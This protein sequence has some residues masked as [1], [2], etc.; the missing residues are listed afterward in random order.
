M[1]SLQTSHD[2]AAAAV[3]VT[4]GA[5]VEV[6]S[7]PASANSAVDA[8]EDFCTWANDAARAW[9]PAALFG[10]SWERQSST[11]GALLKVRNTGGVWS[12]APNGAALA[13]LGIPAQGPGIVASGSTAGV[14]T[15]APGPGGLLPLRLGQ[16]WWDKSPG[17]ASGVGT[18]RPVVPAFSP[19][20]GVCA[21]IVGPVETMR[22]P[23]IVK[24]CSHP[25]RAWLRLSSVQASEW[26]VPPAGY[27][28]LRLGLGA[29]QRS[30]AGVRLW[31]FELQLVGEAA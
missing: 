1:L 20:A 31:R 9:W 5:V 4:V 17:Q 15:W 25:R 2:W 24:L 29:V 27:G 11:G 18:V 21:P 23:E 26:T 14:G 10:W 8:L 3:T 12:W 7:C 28:W 30:R 19:Y 16:T 22:W 13:L 6:W